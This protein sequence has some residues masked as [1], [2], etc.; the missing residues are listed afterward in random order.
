MKGHRHIL[1]NKKF[2]KNFLLFALFWRRDWLREIPGDYERTKI[3]DEVAMPVDRECSEIDIWGYLL[4]PG[5]IVDMM[6]SSGSTSLNI[7]G[8]LGA[9][10]RLKK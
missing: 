7:V 1:W 2:K 10:R 9:V 6:N 5:P 8:F 3:A 4:L